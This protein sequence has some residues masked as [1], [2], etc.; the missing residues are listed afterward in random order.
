MGEGSTD[1]EG[2]AQTGAR[3]RQVRR[4]RRVIAGGAVVLVVV[5]VVAAFA[6]LLWLRPANGP[7]QLVSTDGWQTYTD[8]QKLFS[9]KAPADWNVQQDEESGG[10]FSN[11]DGSYSYTGEDVWLGIPPESI[12]GLGININVM[13]LTTDFARKWECNDSSARFTP[14]GALATVPAYYDGLSMWMMDT[15]D[16]NFQINAN[17]PGGPMSPHS[18]SPMTGPVPTPTPVPADELATGQQDIST[19]L[20]TFPLTNPTALDC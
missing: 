20:A 17:Y 11:R 19:A 7:Q 6:T 4:L 16:A 14:N 2:A 9:I 10:S 5:A 18:S 8:P 12:Y 1:E 15:H 3:P 13:P